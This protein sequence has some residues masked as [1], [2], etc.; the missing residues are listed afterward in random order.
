[1]KRSVQ[2]ST[3]T[4]TLQARSDLHL[5][6]KTWH[7]TMGV[8][9]AFIYLAGLPAPTALFILILALGLAMFVETM[10]LRNP[11]INEKVLRYWGPLMRNCEIGRVSG[12]PHYLAATIIAIAIF[13]KPVAVL[14]VLYLACGD[15][16]A[17]LCG[18]LYG[19][20][21]PRFASGK[22]LIGTMAGVT[23]CIVISLL[24]LSSLQL[25][26]G[27]LLAVS[28]IGGIAGGTAEL[29]PFDADDNFTIPV[30]SGFV[31][32]LAF[33]VFGI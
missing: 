8:A 32:W 17:S 4:S 20:R 19:N 6:R 16:I 30:I 21:G 18:I 25:S 23:T 5:L 27:T 9:M 15:P 13:P 7:L 31:L 33:I 14:S 2:S 3:L 28:L 29:M 26:T 24:F 22:S 1:M 10:R 11:A 12:V